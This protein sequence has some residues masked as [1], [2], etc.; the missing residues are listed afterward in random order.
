VD[1]SVPHLVRTVRRFVDEEE[2]A[3]KGSPAPLRPARSMAKERHPESAAAEEKKPKAPV[4]YQVSEQ[5]SSKVQEEEF[6]KQLRLARYLAAAN[7][8]P[9]RRLEA[10]PEAKRRNTSDPLQRR[11]LKPRRERPARSPAR[12]NWRKKGGVRDGRVDKLPSSGWRRG[13]KQ[14]PE[15]GR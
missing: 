4:T 1:I 7:L 9:P 11:G 15:R 12:K 5:P 14:R 6:A 8:P 3:G 13:E 10:A 2:R